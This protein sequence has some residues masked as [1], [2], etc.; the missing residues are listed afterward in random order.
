MGRVR[1]AKYTLKI[2]MCEYFPQIAKRDVPRIS[3]EFTAFPHEA[4]HLKKRNKAMMKRKKRLQRKQRGRKK[5]YF[6]SP[7]KNGEN[8]QMSLLDSH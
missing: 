7:E 8:M 4:W 1:M 3:K 2:K 6:A 5:W